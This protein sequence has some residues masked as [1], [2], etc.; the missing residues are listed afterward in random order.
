MWQ[1]TELA[2]ALHQ[3]R[4]AEAQVRPR[5]RR[6]PRNRPAAM[7]VCPCPAAVPGAR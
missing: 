3:A 2:R 7:V 1:N 6:E 5:R 4:I